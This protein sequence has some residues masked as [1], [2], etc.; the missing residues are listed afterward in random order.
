[1][2]TGQI[3]LPETGRSAGG[4]PSDFLTCFARPC[5]VDLVP[6]AATAALRVPSLPAPSGGQC[7]ERP[8][9]LQ[10]TE[11]PTEAPPAGRAWRPTSV[12]PPA[13]QAR[14]PAAVAPPAGQARRPAALAGG[15]LSSPTESHR[16]LADTRGLRRKR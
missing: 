15:G 7:Q 12:A 13:G 11:S 8:R 5:A 1:M 4:H 2:D 9:S 6:S 14:R 3:S 10:A 16:C